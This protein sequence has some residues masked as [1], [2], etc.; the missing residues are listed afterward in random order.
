[1][2]CSGSEFSVI[3]PRSE[4]NFGGVTPPTHHEGIYLADLY[5]PRRRIAREYF[6]VFAMVIAVMPIIIF[7]GVPTLLQIL[8]ARPRHGDGLLFGQKPT[9]I[10]PHVYPYA[11]A[12]YAYVVVVVC[13]NRLCAAGRSPWWLLVPGYNVYLLFFAP[14]R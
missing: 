7:F 13:V 2:I 4:A 10:A 8:A 11:Y 9:E 3:L 1:M 12:V 6:V 14:D 5:D